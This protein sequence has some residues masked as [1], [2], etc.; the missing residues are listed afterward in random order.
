MKTQSLLA[1]VV[2]SA[3]ALSLAPQAQAQAVSVEAGE[4]AWYPSLESADA[5]RI[6]ALLADDF[7]YQHPTGATYAKSDIVREFSTRNVTVDEVGPVERTLKTL[8]DA[9]VVYGSNRIGG[10]LGGQRYAGTMRFVNVWR[11]D[12]DGWRMVH[13]NSEILP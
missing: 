13:R 8:G 10:L 2:L 11:R 12:A 1:A 7:A 4:A 6:A 9:T 5:G 3:A